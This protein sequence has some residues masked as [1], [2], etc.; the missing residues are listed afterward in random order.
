MITN[1]FFFG[2]GGGGEA[3]HFRGEASTSQIKYPRQNP[4]SQSQEGVLPSQLTIVECYHCT[5]RLYPYFK[6][7]FLI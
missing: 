4:D 2:G 6:I 3:G 5:K 7:N 1:C